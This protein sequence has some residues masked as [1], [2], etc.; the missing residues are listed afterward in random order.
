MS[1]FAEAYADVL[2]KEANRKRRMRIGFRI[3]LVCVF[4]TLLGLAISYSSHHDATL[5]PWKMIAD[6]A[7]LDTS[8]GWHAVY[9]AA[10]DSTALV[11]IG[12]QLDS[13]AFG[14]DT[15]PRAAA[16]FRPLPKPPKFK[17]GY[18]WSM[19]AMDSAKTLRG[20]R[21]MAPLT[22]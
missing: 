16:I 9:Y 3:T 5:R 22:H 17:A 8:T 21:L 4:M 15:I 2:Q 13:N 14:E 7:A 20:L 1:K 11:S 6:T 19:S 12:G 10:I 18:H